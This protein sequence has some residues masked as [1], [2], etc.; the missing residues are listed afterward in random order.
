M[1]EKI[2]LGKTVGAFFIVLLL[3]PLGHALMILMEHT[4]APRISHVAL[5]AFCWMYDVKSSDIDNE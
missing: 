4:L 1:K 5:V 2:Y 3:V